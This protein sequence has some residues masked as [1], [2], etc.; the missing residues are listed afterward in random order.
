[1]KTIHSIIWVSLMLIM[2]SCKETDSVQLSQVSGNWQSE[3]IYINGQLQDA[4]LSNSTHLNLQEDLQYI[5]NYTSGTWK[6]EAN[7][8]ELIPKQELALPSRQYQIVEYSKEILV[9]EVSL[10]EKEYDWNFDDI[11][12]DEVIK[13]KEIFKRK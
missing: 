4:N 6:L 8:I 12:A 11:G 7:S 13:V 9:L 2:I 1:M 3:E 5:R 10:T